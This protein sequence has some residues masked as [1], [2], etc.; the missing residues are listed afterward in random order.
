MKKYMLLATFTDEG[1]LYTV[2]E[3]Y[4]DMNSVETARMYFIR[5]VGAQCDVY[6]FNSEHGHYEF[7]YA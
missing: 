4:D 3:F 7:L 1:E 6:E 5:W 2:T